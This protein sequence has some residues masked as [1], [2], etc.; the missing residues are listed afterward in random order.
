LTNVPG[1]LF[2]F[3]PTGSNL[4]AQGNYGY[5]ATNNLTPVT[6]TLPL[7]ANI[8]IGSTVRVSGSGTAGWIVAQN[9]NQVIQVANLTENVG[10]VWRTN[11]TSR[12]WKAVAASSDGSKL[13]AVVNPGNIFT[14]TNYGANWGVKAG[15]LGS[16]GWSSVASSADG[17]KLVA[18]VNGGSIY[19]STDSGTNWGLPFGP[20]TW[21]SVA[22]SWD[23][24]RLFG[25]FR[26]LHIC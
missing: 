9:S 5:L 21:T 16:L 3:V 26:H 20:A 12:N 25:E 24:S 4:T 7:T 17:S 2:D 6:I 23:V 13:V 11:E 19:T 15:G 22:S 1:R 8:P 14:S 10:F 18:C